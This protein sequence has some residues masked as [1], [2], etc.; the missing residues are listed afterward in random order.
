LTPK[1]PFCIFKFIKLSNYQTNLKTEK[2][3]YWGKEGEMAENRRPGPLGLGNDDPIDTGTL[4]RHRSASPGPL[5]LDSNDKAEL[6]NA[7]SLLKSEALNF[8]QRFIHDYAVRMDYNRQAGFVAR[9]I[10]EEVVAGRLTPRQGA[11]AANKI[12][13]AI[14]D[15][16]RLSS[17]DF[18]RAI[19]EKTKGAG[20]LLPDLEVHYAQKILNKNFAEL[21]QAQKNQVW[22]EII[23]S[24]GRPRQDVTLATLRLSKVGRGLI[25]IS[26]ACAVYNV[27]TAENKERQVVKEGVT[28]GA[29]F[30]GAMGGGALAGL[31]CGPGAPVCVGLG[32]FIAGAL[33][34]LGADFAFDSL[35]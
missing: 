34:A 11:E 12:R 20:R 22:L 5:G 21:S 1:F 18:G 29:G 26:V 13:N 35:W 33:A 2:I 10:R 28:A 31:V 24:S 17:S 23:E 25:F 27:T 4:V 9:V 15:A 16:S 32:V 3:R 19:A 30:L 14:L 8:G 7:L 6:E